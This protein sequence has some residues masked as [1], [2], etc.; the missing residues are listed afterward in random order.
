MCSDR[1]DF[2]LNFKLGDKTGIKSTEFYQ[3]SSLLAERTGIYLSEN[4][5]AM[6]EARLAK[7]LKE[8]NLKSYTDYVNYLRKNP[9]EMTS[10]VNALTTNKTDFFREPYHFEYLE[11]K[12]LPEFVKRSKD[13]KFRLWSGA[14][15]T[16]DELYTLGMVISEFF[17]THPGFDYKLLGTDID[18][19][20]LSKAEK[21]EYSFDTIKPVPIHLIGKYFIKD[22][23][24]GKN[25]FVANNE[26][27]KI[28]KFRQFNL[29]HDDLSNSI[30]FDVIFLRNV[31][32]YFTA[33]TIE[34]VINKMYERLN[35]RGYLFI[36]HSEAL[37]NVKHRFQF[38]H[39]SI[40]YKE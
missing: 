30:K 24:N 28:I 14:S 21:G 31:L 12:V 25:I 15:S 13:K 32:I 37:N 11:K 22:S 6:V 34:L 16:G 17:T 39:N 40:Y 19:S 20:V 36:G 26:L 27:R 23:Q 10:F 2:G 7:R 3:V 33:E 9:N 1:I 35:P 8:L 38:L 4:K 5:M 29:I 18:T